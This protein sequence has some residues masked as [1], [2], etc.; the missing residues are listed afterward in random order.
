M[1]ALS[2]LETFRSNT[3]LR[4]NVGDLPR[5]TPMLQPADEFG[6]G[7]EFDLVVLLVSLFSPSLLHAAAR[8]L[9]LLG[10]LAELIIIA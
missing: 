10:P 8:L 7:L 3:Q 2:V 4:M 9:L 5:P 6:A 1:Y